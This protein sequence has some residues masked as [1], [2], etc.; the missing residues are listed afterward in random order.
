MT[1]LIT[2]QVV[3]EPVA[4]LFDISSLIAHQMEVG[5]SWGWYVLRRRTITRFEKGT[6][7]RQTRVRHSQVNGRKCESLMRYLYLL[8]SSLSSNFAVRKI[9]IASLTL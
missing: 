5:S 2:R 4:M 7:D 6:T 9:L 8:P 1:E 3:A